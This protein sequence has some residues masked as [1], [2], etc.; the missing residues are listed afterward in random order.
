MFAFCLRAPP[1][2]GLAGLPRSTA[3]AA[4]ASIARQL[5]AA[6][7][8]MFNIVLNVLNVVL[9]MFDFVLKMLDF[10]LKMFDFV[11]KML[12]FV[13]KMFDFVLKM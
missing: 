10:V 13:L 11:L 3:V 5:A 8:L 2:I 1:R 6:G 4:P 12:D 7:I 9:N